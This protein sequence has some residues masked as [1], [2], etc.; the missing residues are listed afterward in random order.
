MYL[1]FYSLS[2]GIILWNGK[3]RDV[4]TKICENQE[5]HWKYCVKSSLY[6]KISLLGQATGF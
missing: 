4:Y 5:E 3:M 1:P 2:F 6:S